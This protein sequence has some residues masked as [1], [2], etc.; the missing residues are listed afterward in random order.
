MLTLA[1]DF[2][3]TSRTERPVRSADLI[4]AGPPSVGRSP[5]RF[6]CQIGERAGRQ[7]AISPS[8]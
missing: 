3:A 8:L 1:P 7:K 5:R 6:V 2:F 4:V